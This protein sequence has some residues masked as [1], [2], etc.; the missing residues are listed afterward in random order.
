MLFWEPNIWHLNI[1]TGRETPFIPLLLPEWSQELPGPHGTQAAHRVIPAELHGT[2][3]HN[4]AHQLPPQSCILE[5]LPRVLCSLAFNSSLLCQHLFQ[6]C[7]QVTGASELLQCCKDKGTSYCWAFSSVCCRARDW[8]AGDACTKLQSR[9]CAHAVTFTE[10]ISCGAATWKI[11]GKG[12]TNPWPLFENWVFPNSAI[13]AA[14]LLTQISSA[15]PGKC[16][17]LRCSWYTAHTSHKIT[18]ATLH[19]RICMPQ[20]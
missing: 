4:D 2:A 5:Q 17:Q 18:P 19:M 15:S 9:A 20:I 11:W 8:A 1:S 12:S 14:M 6:L 16:R 10:L 3:Q 7:T 13:L